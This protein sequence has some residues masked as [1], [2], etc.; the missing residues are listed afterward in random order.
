M[1]TNKRSYDIDIDD[2]RNID[3][4]FDRLSLQDFR[5]LNNM[6]KFSIED[7]PPAKLITERLVTK[8]MVRS[9]RTPEYDWQITE[10]GMYLL[11]HIHNVALSEYLKKKK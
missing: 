8:V 3:S 2:F 7:Q 11:S 1:D 4:V 10:L 5:F 9:G 6:P